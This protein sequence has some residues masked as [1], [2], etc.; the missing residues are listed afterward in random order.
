VLLEQATLSYVTDGGERP[1]RLGREAG[2]APSAGEAT[3]CCVPRP[4]QLRLTV[5][6]YAVWD[7]TVSYRTRGRCEV[8]IP[9]R[10]AVRLRRLATATVTR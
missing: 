1:T 6:G 2:V 5:P 7:S 8:P 9:T 4:V 10:V 3:V